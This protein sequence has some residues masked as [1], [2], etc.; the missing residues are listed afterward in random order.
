MKYSIII[1]VYNAQDKLRRCLDSIVSQDYYDYELIL[2]NDGSKDNSAEIC[3]EYY[4][5]FAFIKFIDKDNGGASSAR[6]AG[7]DAAKGKYILFVDSDDYVAE[8]YFE[9]INGNETENGLTVFTYT[10]LKNDGTKKREFSQNLL[11]DSVSLFEKVRLLILSRAINAPYSK[12]FDADIIRNNHISFDTSMPVA[13]DFNFALEYLIYCKEIMIVDNSIYFYDLTNS[14]SLVHKRKEGLINI[15]PLVFKKA[16][17][18][19]SQYSFNENENKQLF[20]IVDKLHTDSF[21]TCVMEEQKDKSISFFNALTVIRK[22]C[23]KFYSEF[24]AEY[25]YENM[26][27][28]FVRQC[29]RFR[30]ALTLYV[31]CKVYSTVRR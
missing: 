11:V 14:E 23:A 1:P 4:E 28:F 24:K 21:I 31:M 18:S 13:E 19:V 10:W 6:N 17:T 5:K 20:R 15:Y 22:M 26:V 25:G 3:K 29:I 12:I 16:L 9:E 8:N 30:L 2:V 7:I 27:H